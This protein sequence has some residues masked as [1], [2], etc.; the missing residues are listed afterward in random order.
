M[1]W[2]E[3][4]S[5]EG[6]QFGELIQAVNADLEPDLDPDQQG[7]SEDP[8]LWPHQQ[9]FLNKQIW[10]L[11]L[12]G[13]LVRYIPWAYPQVRNL[14]LAR[15]RLFDEKNLPAAQYVLRHTLG[16]K[17]SS[18][19]ELADQ[20]YD[21]ESDAYSGYRDLIKQNLLDELKEIRVWD[22]EVIKR[23]ASISE[24]EY[25]AGYKVTAA[26]SLLLFHR[27][28]YTYWRRRQ[29]RWF[30]DNRPDLHE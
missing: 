9:D 20:I 8:E 6:P 28:V 11:G 27:H 19:N 29:N 7:V 12:D 2:E 18:L 16:G 15:D 25:I 13:F 24:K 17:P 30:R 10:P 23:K 26:E 21:P 4:R 22:Y 14:N 3:P 1:M 5:P